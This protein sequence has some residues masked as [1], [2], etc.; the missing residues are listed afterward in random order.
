MEAEEEQRLL[1]MEENA[2][3]LDDQLEHDQNTDWLRG[4]GWPTWFV[5]KLLMVIVSWGTGAGLDCVCGDFCG[6]VCE[7]GI[8][9]ADVVSA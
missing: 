3:T 5:G 2:P 4:C 9:L 6:A 8:C 7:L 1:Q